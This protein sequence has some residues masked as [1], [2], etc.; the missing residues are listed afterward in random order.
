MKQEVQCE[1]SGVVGHDFI[2][3]EQEAVEEVFEHGPDDHP[4]YNTHSSGS[5]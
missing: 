4:E 5:E 2:D 1:G 3:V